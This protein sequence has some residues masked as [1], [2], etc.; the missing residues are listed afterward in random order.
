[1]IILDI[2]NIQLPS[3]NRKYGY[4][5]K[6]GQFYLDAKYRELT[7]TLIKLMKDYHRTAKV[8]PPYSVKIY[9]ETYLDAD[10]FVKPLFDGMK[11]AQIIC[12]DRDILFFAVYKKPAKK[13]C[14]SSIKVEVETHGI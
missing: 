5:P 6:S 10:N 1:M 7:G 12:D 4:N 13:G 2:E 9:V 3:V 14:G 11:K 8:E